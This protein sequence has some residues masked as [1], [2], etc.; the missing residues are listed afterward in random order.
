MNIEHCVQNAPTIND[1]KRVASAYVIDYKGLTD[2]EIKGAIIKTAPQYYFEGNVEKSINELILNL[3][4]SVRIIGPYLLKHVVLQKD[5]YVCSKKETD[6]AVLKWEQTIVD[7][8]N[9]DFLH[10]VE[11]RVNEL[12]LMQFVVEVAWENNGQLSVDEKNLIDKIRR[13]LKISNN[14]LRIIEAKLGQFP[15]H[16]NV[17][18]TR[19]EIED[20]RRKLQSK[21]L[22]FAIRDNNGIDYDI[23]PEEVARVIA[24]I[25]DLE[26]RHYGYSQL[27][28]YKFVHSKSYI[29]ECLTKVGIKT[30]KNPTLNTLIKIAIER[31]SPRI[32]LGG[33]S[34][35]D[36]IA[37]GILSKWCAE[38]GLAVSGPKQDLIDRIIS[39]YDALHPKNDQEKDE[40]EVFYKYFEQFA[41]R[42]RDVLHSQQ[43]IDKD[44]EIERRFEEVTKYLFDKLLG[45]KPLKFVGNNHAD[46]A[47]SYKDQ[48]IL[49][50]NKSK[51]S[52]VNLKDHI[53]QF[54]SYIKNSEKP[55]AGFLVI[56]PS[57]TTES[58]KLAMEYQV[59]NSVIMCLITA[60]ELKKVADTWSSKSTGTAFPIGYLLQSGRFNP[61]LVIGL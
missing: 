61:D 57:F 41:W 31:L 50:D 4:R 8:A 14:E 9:E 16:S 17:L 18:H 6:E 49:W 12:E 60:S 48:I 35:R 29:L 7:Q 54:D 36:G 43:L 2:S 19:Q 51:E 44:L 20:V 40:R 22:L 23:I 59:N 11:D 56:G 21:G 52:E 34:P 58:S 26:I 47:L 37:I 13:R 55:V 15:K 39:F 28:K 33:T 45:H 53:R 32:L 1:L 24:K 27:L 25:M 3:N 46:G 10:I 42:D 38:L 30:E 5:K